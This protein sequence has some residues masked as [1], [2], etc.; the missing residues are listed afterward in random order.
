VHGASGL[1][2]NAPPDFLL[3]LDASKPKSI[4]G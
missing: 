1:I 4:F 3:D 2:T